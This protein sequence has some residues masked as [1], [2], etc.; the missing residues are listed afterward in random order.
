MLLGIWVEDVPAVVYKLDWL[1]FVVRGEGSW[2][3]V[4]IVVLVPKGRA[5]D[6]AW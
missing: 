4:P 1:C 3:V 2:D 6:V 5:E